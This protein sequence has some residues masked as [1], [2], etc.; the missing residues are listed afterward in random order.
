MLSSQRLTF[1][2]PVAPVFTS[3]RGSAL[4]RLQLPSTSNLLPRHRHLRGLLIRSQGFKESSDFLTKNDSNHSNVEPSNGLDT[5]IKGG[6]SLLSAAT[7]LLSTL[8]T[9]LDASA[10]YT[11]APPFRL[12]GEE[13]TIVKLFNANTPSVVYINNLALR[14]DDFTLDVLSVP[15][16]SGSG[17]VWDNDGHIVTNFHVIRG[18]QNISVTLINQETF[19]AT[20]V[21]FDP[22]KDVAVLKIDAKKGDL[23]PINV[24]TS[25]GLQVGQTVYAIGN[26]FGLD[27]T[28]TMG[29]ISGLNRE[30][31][32]A[33]NMR[34]IQNAIQ[35]DAAIN[36]GNSGGPLL[37]SAGSLIGMNTAIY[38]SSGTSSGVGFAI[39]IDT[40][41]GIVEQIIKFGKVT[42][43]VIG[44]SLA[45]D[46]ALE[47]L[48]VKG[49]L[50]L[51]AAPGSPAAEAGIRAS[52][53]DEFGRLVLGDIITKINGKNIKNAS[54]LFRFLDTC[55]VG[56]TIQIEVLRGDGYAKLDLT[57]GEQQPAPKP[58][59]MF[60]AE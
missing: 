52:R 2:A 54:D 5:A 57:L 23:R 6:I 49:V 12:S 45:P 18:A 60:M 48:G 43:P 31:D 11:S 32:N 16:G 40:I 14:R 13:G 17:F 7:L 20:V 15:Q 24:G 51:D 35:T 9:P 36:P 19:P 44:I 39:P 33:I 26:P 59:K 47:Q 42:R 3:K 25:E 53:R 41:S 37:N 28:L 22:D 34:P 10:M 30:I 1:Q 58:V 56:Q 8:V 50:V 55:K 21:G 29:I 4:R 46:V 27:H 38:S